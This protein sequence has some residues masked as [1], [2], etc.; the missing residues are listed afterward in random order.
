MKK[1]SFSI[2]DIKYHIDKGNFIKFTDDQQMSLL[3]YANE[4]GYSIDIQDNYAILQDDN[5]AKEYIVVFLDTFCHLLNINGNHITYENMREYFYMHKALF[6]LLKDTL[7][8]EMKRLMS[9]ICIKNISLRDKS[10]D[11]EKRYIQR[12]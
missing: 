9:S 2:S 5:G 7:T 11:H 6:P 4:L 1:K 3:E 8:L 10:F 12:A